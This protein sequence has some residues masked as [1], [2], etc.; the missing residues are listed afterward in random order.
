MHDAARRQRPCGHA[1]LH[2]AAVVVTVA[3]SGT[4]VL[5]GL[6]EAEGYLLDEF[7]IETADGYLLT[8]FRLSN[9]HVKAVCARTRACRCATVGHDPATRRREASFCCS[10]GSFRPLFRSSSIR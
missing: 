10:T 9:P 2:L 7:E 3:R 4:A 6:V 8:M 5:R 1:T